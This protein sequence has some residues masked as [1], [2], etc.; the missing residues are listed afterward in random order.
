MRSSR[1]ATPSFP[2]C[3]RFSPLLQYCLFGYVFVYGAATAFYVVIHVVSMLRSVIEFLFNFVLS[4]SIFSFTSTPFFFVVL[5]LL[6]YSYSFCVP[7]NSDSS[8]IRISHRCSLNRN[9]FAS[10]SSTKGFSRTSTQ[11]FCSLYS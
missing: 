2:H 9:R 5:L 3:S 1:R 4:S 6:D 7:P 8:S 11:H 10:K